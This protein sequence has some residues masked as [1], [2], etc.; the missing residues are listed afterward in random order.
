[1]K[2]LDPRDATSFGS[3]RAAADLCADV[4]MLF[5]SFLKSLVTPQEGVNPFILNA[6]LVAS[7]ISAVVSDLERFKSFHSLEVVSNT[8]QAA[9]VSYWINKFKPIQI[10]GTEQAESASL[11]FV[12]EMFAAYLLL[13]FARIHPVS[14]NESTYSSLIYQLKYSDL[15]TSSLYLIALAISGKTGVGETEK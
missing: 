12:N 15:S 5:N 11:V 9:F 7:S 4:E 10:V 8:R 2:K 6:T 1:M 3:R 14:L 13:A